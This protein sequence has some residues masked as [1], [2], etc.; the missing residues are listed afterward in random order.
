MVKISKDTAITFATATESALFMGIATRYEQL[1]QNKVSSTFAISN[2]DNVTSTLSSVVIS[3]D[4]VD[5]KLGSSTCENYTL[6]VSSDS[7]AI[8]SCSI[9]GARHAF[10]P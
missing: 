5:E 10:C 3:L 8:S 6:T 1:I 9:Y 2:D 7:A 4:S